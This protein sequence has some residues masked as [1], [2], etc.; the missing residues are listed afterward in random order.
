MARPR[1]RPAGR[2]PGCA[3]PPTGRA[4]SVRARR[5]PPGHRHRRPLRGLHPARAP[6]VAPPALPRGRLRGGAPCARRRPRGSAAARRS[7]RSRRGCPPGALRC[8]AAHRSCR[9]PARLPARARGASAAPRAASCQLP[10][11]GVARP[12]LAE[13]RGELQPSASGTDTTRQRSERVDPS[14]L[15]AAKRWSVPCALPCSS[16]SNAARWAGSSPDTSS[17]GTGWPASSSGPAPSSA[18]APTPHS[19]TTPSGVL[20]T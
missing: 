15:R 19:A 8:R 7:R 18:L 6:R 3:R 1:P 16:C 20:S 17:S 2:A 12:E 5:D 13:Q 4:A 9:R 14:A 10:A 11:V